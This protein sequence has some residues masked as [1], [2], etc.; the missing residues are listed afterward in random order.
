MGRIR[1]QKVNWSDQLAQLIAY[2]DSLYRLYPLD[3]Q[4]SAR[5]AP[6][7]FSAA[8]KARLFPVSQVIGCL[9][10]GPFS[11]QHVENHKRY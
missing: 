5:T 6:R 7:S 4:V 8:A 2:D 9:F 1:W 10:I 3:E 11:S